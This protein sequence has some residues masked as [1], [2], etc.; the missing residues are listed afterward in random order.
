MIKLDVIKI[1]K[2][3]ATRMNLFVL[4]S[5]PKIAARYHLDK[6]VVKMILEACQ[7]LYT[8]HW[9]FAYPELLDCK[10][11]IALSKKQK[12]LSPPQSIL[13]APVS[14]TRSDEPGFRPCHIHHPCAKWV[15][16]TVGN[17]KWA[18]ELALGLAQEYEY[19][20][21][22]HGSH[23]CKE[24]AKWLYENPPKEISQR[25]RTKFVQAMEE[26]FRQK[27]AIQAYRMYYTISKG[28]E[29]GMLKYTRRE[30]PE[31]LI[32]SKENT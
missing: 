24:H 10:S 19:R 9:A 7:L 16:K 22:T 27:D 18:A 6:H 29:R 3:K 17:Y 25:A 30:L 8:A 23:S 15:R 1:H 4:S 13:S 26:R 14:K 5:H 12:E 20:W 32:E 31:F 28:E 2:L 21:P 11:A